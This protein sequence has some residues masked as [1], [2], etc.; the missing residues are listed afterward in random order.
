[1]IEVFLGLGS[2]AERDDHLRRGLDALEQLLGPL[3]LSPVFESEAVGVLGRRFYNMVVGAYTH[4]PL[5]D[6]NAA[7]KAIEAACG[8]REQVSPGR[9][10]LDIDILTYGQLCGVHDGMRLPRAE[11]ARNA[12]VLWPL[13]LLAP[14]ARLP[15]DGRSYLELWTSWQGDQALWPVAFDWRGRALSAPELVAE[16][17]AR[18]VSAK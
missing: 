2:N 15:G 6:L 16:H 18:A 9:I 12:F 7:L 13:A 17:Q 11:T 8:R 5:A 4:L 3:D 1:M 14:H 10:T